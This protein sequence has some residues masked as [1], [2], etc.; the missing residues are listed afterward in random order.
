MIL[1][2]I[3]SSYRLDFITKG[4]PKDISKPGSFIYSLFEETHPDRDPAEGIFFQFAEFAPDPRIIKTHLPFSLLSPLL[5]DTCKIIYMARE[6]KDVAVSYCH[7]S[8]LLKDHNFIGTIS[9]FVDHFVNDT[10]MFSPYWKHVKEAWNRRDQSNI[11]FCFFEDLRADPKAEIV[12]LQKFFSLSLTDDQIDNIVYHTSFQV[13]KE[14]EG[15]KL[16][17]SNTGSSHNAEVEE[18]DG[19][20]FRKGISG[21]YKN[22]LSKK[23]IAKIDQWTR[24]NTKEM[25]N[26]F[27]YKINNL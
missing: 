24:E 6:P 7:H 12:R 8:R 16:E 5:P 14:R 23:D 15:Q 21:D 20:F 25:E 19:G 22:H 10:T 9:Q 13:M 18:K 4:L 17:G 27:K 11:H 2:T 1:K 26:D 3:N